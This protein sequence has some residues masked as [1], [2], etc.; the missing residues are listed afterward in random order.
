MQKM[1]YTLKRKTLTPKIDTIFD[2]SFAINSFL[3][4]AKKYAHTPAFTHKTLTNYIL[5]SFFVNYVALYGLCAILIPSLKLFF[6]LIK[7]MMLFLYKKTS[8]R[9]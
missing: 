9:Q 1:P 7:N 4:A 3:Y 2:L 5:T 6:F 8:R